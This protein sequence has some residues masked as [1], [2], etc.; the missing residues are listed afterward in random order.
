MKRLAFIGSV[1]AAGLLVLPGAGALAQ[2]QPRAV[3]EL[4]TSQGCSSCPPADKLFVEL[5]RDP[6]MIALTLPVDYWDYLGWKDTLANPAFSSR[7]R[8]YAQLRGDSNVYTPQAVVNGV[9]HLLGSDKGKIGKHVAAAVLPV[10]MTLAE[11]ADGIVITLPAHETGRSLAS[12]GAR[13]VLFLMPVTARAEVMIAR[14]ENRGKT[15][16]YANVV[17]DIHPVGEWTGE[18]MAINLP[19]AKLAGL[20]GME[21]SD[22]FVVMLQSEGKK[23]AK[24]LGAIRSKGLEPPAS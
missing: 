1:V 13:G 20:A 22:G 5:A 9:G 11:T 18:A 17:R 2:T 10:S 14:G 16:S 8:H 7:Q 21:G 12:K 15:I 4:F 24:I 23:G 19:K 3:V 6:S